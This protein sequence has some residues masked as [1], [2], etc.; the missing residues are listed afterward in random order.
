MKISVAG[1]GYVGLSTTV[2]LAQHHEVT[3]LTTT[4]N[5]T[6]DLSAVV[7][8]QSEELDEDV[9]LDSKYLTQFLLNTC[10]FLPGSNQ[11][12]EGCYARSYIFQQDLPLD[13]DVLPGYETLP[14]F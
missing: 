13:K 4:P 10:E 7:A 11:N 2:S 6:T 12:P 3:A 5:Y 1:I 9:L 14:L 8:L